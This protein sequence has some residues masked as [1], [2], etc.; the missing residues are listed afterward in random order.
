MNFSLDI[1]TES[2]YF[3]KTAFLWVGTEAVKRGG[4]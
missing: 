2:S 1:K 3:Y 4:L